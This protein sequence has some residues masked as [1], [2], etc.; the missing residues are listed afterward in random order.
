M[1]VVGG[2]V[3]GVAVAD[4]VGLSIAG[5]DGVG[6]S[7]AA[8]LAAVQAV[9]SNT[10]SA[11]TRHQL[12]FR[13]VLQSVTA[14]RRNCYSSGTAGPFFPL[15]HAPAGLRPTS[16]PRVQAPAGLPSSPG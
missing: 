16:D 6:L 12:P 14:A 10:V 8:G 13:I 7:A 11:S 4:G 15:V 9:A 5:S 1:A 3:V 2:E